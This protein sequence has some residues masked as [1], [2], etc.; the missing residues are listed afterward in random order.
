MQKP[1]LFLVVLAS[2]FLTTNVTG[3]VPQ[4]MNY[5]GVLTGSDGK[6][7][8][9]QEVTIDFII[10]DAPDGGETKWQEMQVD[11]TDNEGAVSIILGS[12]SSIP[13][14]VFNQPNRW[15]GVSINGDS[16][17]S[18][19]TMLA[20]A[21]YA[22]QSIHADT[23]QYALAAAKCGWEDDGAVVRLTTA[24]D[25]V[26]IGTD[27]P[28]ERLEVVGNILVSGTATI[29]PDH[30]NTGASAF[31]SG[32]NNAVIGDFSNVG[33]G[34]HNIAR[35]YYSTVTGGGGAD[36]ADSNAALGD[37][38][39]VGG[40][41]RNIASNTYSS[42]GGGGSN[43][44]NGWA[45]V[46]GGGVNNT[47]SEYSFIGGGSNCEASGDWSTVCGGRRDSA[48]G[49]YS[50]VVGGVNN[51][52]SGNWSVVSG[53]SENC[54]GPGEYCTVAGGVRDSATALAATVCGGYENRARGQYGTVGG[55]R[56]NI[57][58]GQWSVVCGG[59]ENSA[60]GH[61]SIV[62]GGSQNTA[63]GNNSFAAGHRAK[64]NHIGSFV[65]ADNVDRDFESVSPS[66]FAVRSNGGA[67]FVT[68]VDVNGDPTAGVFIPA[69]GNAWES[70]S[71]RNA[72]ENFLPVDGKEILRRLSLIP[73]TTWN[74]KSENKLIRHIGP[75]A[76]DFYA[77]F[78][79]GRDNKR[80]C[81]ID[82]D[83]VA[84]A[85]IQ[86]LYRKNQ[87]LEDEVRELKAL[88]QKLLD[89]NGR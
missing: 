44:A 32:E 14:T 61:Y 62:C 37:Y 35:G 11:T 70:I 76:Q 73:I 47:A 4:M 26:G 59:Q 77:A 54:S 22:Y 60:T 49:Q 25:S 28:G 24:S 15:L 31:V 51:S 17:I 6:P 81:T 41:Y 2:V 12:V 52:C 55:G 65:F 82:P 3:E 75:M 64:A 9:N 10:Y 78:E 39:S 21:P 63:G 13:D 33:G 38:S 69:G 30:T 42:V 46:V 66:E 71:D 34:R 18:P 83:G 88:L 58:E 27:S 7:I 5:Q 87:D 48:S 19:R 8:R 45:A 89:Q 80:I 68:T 67:R 72:K 29:G 56:E 16:E 36:V 74:Y 79:L 53:G 23:A 1:G 57:S 43:S 50:V 40:G 85:A 20:T 84:L 86:A